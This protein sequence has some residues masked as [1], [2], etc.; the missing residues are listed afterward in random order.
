MT[1]KTKITV[2]V[3]FEV[4]GDTGPSPFQRKAGDLA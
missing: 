4:V 1:A 3:E 2:Q